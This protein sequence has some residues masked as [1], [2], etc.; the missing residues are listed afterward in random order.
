MFS[1]LVNHNNPRFKKVYYAA[2]TLF[3]VY[4]ICVFVLLVYNTTLIFIDLESKYFN[5]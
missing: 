5:D 1:C 3:G 4:G 2:S